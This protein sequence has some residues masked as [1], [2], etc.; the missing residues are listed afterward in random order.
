MNNNYPSAAGSSCG[1]ACCCGGLHFCIVLAA[2]SRLFASDTGSPRPADARQERPLR[3]LCGKLL[4]CQLSAYKMAP[5]LLAGGEL[6]TKRIL[7]SILTQAKRKE[8]KLCQD[9]RNCHSYFLCHVQAANHLSQEHFP[10]FP[11][12]F[13]QPLSRQSSHLSATA[14]CLR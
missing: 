11:V 1:K 7:V 2:I 3:G 9:F 8:S 4:V 13:E 12:K 5:P 14:Y 6:P 10:A